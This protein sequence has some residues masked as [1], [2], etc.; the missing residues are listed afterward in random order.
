M[1]ENEFNAAIK[2]ICWE[3]AEPIKQK[4]MALYDYSNPENFST[5]H[6]AN[7]SISEITVHARDLG[8]VNSEFDENEINWCVE[9]FIREADKA[10]IIFTVRLSA[11]CKKSLIADDTRSE[12]RFLAIANFTTDN[13]SSFSVTKATT[14]H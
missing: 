13:I 12:E 14:V 6:Y 1:R 10:L 7:N 5:N 3:K 4:L 11:P 9:E 8:I 2:N